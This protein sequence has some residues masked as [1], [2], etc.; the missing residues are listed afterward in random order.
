MDR[1]TILVADDVK[2]NRLIIRKFLAKDY[3]VLEACDGAEAIK[4]LEDNHVDAVILD[5]IMPEIDGLRVIELIKDR[6]EWQNIAILV[7]TNTKENTERAALNIGADDIVSKPY[8]PIVIKRRLENI[9]SK[10]TLE[11]QYT[12]D[13]EQVLQKEMAGIVKKRYA[14]QLHSTIDNLKRLAL[15]IETSVDNTKLMASCAHQLRQEADKLEKL[16]VE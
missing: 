6:K 7:A 12:A 15:V 5:I 9:L 16:D 3:N 8:D 13:T 10:K 2:M 11:K 1:L 4:L 14:A